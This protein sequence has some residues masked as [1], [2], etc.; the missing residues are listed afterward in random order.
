MIDVSNVREIIQNVGQDRRT[1]NRQPPTNVQCPI[2]ITNTNFAIET[3]CGHVFCGTCIINYWQV[4][5]NGLFVTQMRCPMCRQAL[6][7]LLTMFTDAEMRSDDIASISRRVNEYNRKFSGLPRPFI[8]Y[9][10]ELPTLLRHAISQ[11]F[12]LDGLHIWYRIRVIFFIVIAVTYLLS[13]F[14]ILP[15]SVYGIIGLLDDILIFF[16]VAIYISI[17]FRQYIANRNF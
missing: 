3:N 14:D 5:S 15:E 7:C 13:P 12:S 2:C 1:T 16:F 10:M 11:L 6:T 8:E 9:I 17:I 4:S